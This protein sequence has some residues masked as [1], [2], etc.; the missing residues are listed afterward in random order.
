MGKV[1]NVFNFKQT[2]LEIGNIYGLP[3]W[4]MMLNYYG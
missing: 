2:A 4:K 1:T 3:G